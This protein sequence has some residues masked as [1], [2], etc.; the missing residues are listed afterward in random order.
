[1]SK[2]RIVLGEGFLYETANGGFDLSGENY[3]S[4]GLMKPVPKELLDSKIKYRV[5]LEKV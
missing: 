1:M 3:Q 4:F 5:V 2:D